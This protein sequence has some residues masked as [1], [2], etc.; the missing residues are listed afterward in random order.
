[1]GDKIDQ[2]TFLGECSD[3]V[4]TTHRIYGSDRNLDLSADAADKKTKILTTAW[5]RLP[6][7]HP[8]VA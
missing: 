6:A 7:R 2:L 8:I 1:M 4:L 3:A 5:I